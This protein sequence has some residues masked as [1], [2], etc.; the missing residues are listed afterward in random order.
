MT[1]KNN[2][3]LPSIVDRLV[4][5]HPTSVCVYIIRRDPVSLYARVYD[6]GAQPRVSKPAAEL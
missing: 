1:P 3:A 5:A 2:N 4:N 6:I